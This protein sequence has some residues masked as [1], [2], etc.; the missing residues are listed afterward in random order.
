MKGKPL[1]AVA[2]PSTVA[3]GRTRAG[4]LEASRSPMESHTGAGRFCA[5]GPARR[6]VRPTLVGALCLV[7][8]LGVV[9]PASA[10][11]VSFTHPTSLS[12]PL[13][14]AE[15]IAVGDFNGDSDPDLATANFDVTNAS[16]TVSILL[17]AAGGS[18]TEPT[19]FGAGTGSRSVA[20]G[21]FNADS[22]PDLAVVNESSLNVSIL[23]GAAG[24]SFTGPTNFGAG[25]APIS[26]AV[27]DFNG[28]SDPDVA[29]ANHETSA[30]SVGVSVLLGAAGWSFAA[31]THFPAGRLPPS[32]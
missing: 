25:D 1:F 2:R 20:V 22:D 28:D 30:S 26:L 13:V 15:A 16:E 7:L 12:L 10:R 17:G 23:L 19:D 11:P 18:F 14:T 31:P 4:P 3:S 21:D 9:A 6:R 27:G 29:V 24:G 32:V 5:A 8:L